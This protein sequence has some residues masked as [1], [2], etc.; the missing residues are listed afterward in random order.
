MIAAANR[1]IKPY[2]IDV[3]EV[4][5]WSIYDIG[6]SITDRFDDVPEGSVSIR[7]DGSP[8]YHVPLDGLNGKMLRDAY[9]KEAQLLFTA[10]AREVLFGDIH[11]TRCTAGPLLL[12]RLTSRDLKKEKVTRYAQRDQDSGMSSARAA[13]SASEWTIG[14]TPVLPSRWRWTT[15]SSAS[16]ASPSTST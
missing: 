14:R 11:D 13:A 1:I 15:R 5:W 12:F 4:V 16:T 3:K 7:D 6:H 2:S 8:A 9:R 10:G